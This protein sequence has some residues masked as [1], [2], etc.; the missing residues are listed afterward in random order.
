[1]ETN[2]VLQHER[3]SATQ[4]KAPVLGSNFIGER[5]T[6]KWKIDAEV[7]EHDVVVPRTPV[8]APSPDGGD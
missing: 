5:V 6:G 3:T 7:H 8:R 2:D 1:M 4:A